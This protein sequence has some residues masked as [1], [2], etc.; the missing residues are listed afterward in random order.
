MLGKGELDS[1]SALELSTLT[2]NWLSAKYER[3]E[4]RLKTVHVHGAPEQTIHISGGLPPLP[5]TNIT[6]PVLNGADIDGHALLEPQAP[7][8][9]SDPPPEPPPE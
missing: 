5:G 3:E 2:R 4:L 1:Q 9:S 8:P 7:E 6:M